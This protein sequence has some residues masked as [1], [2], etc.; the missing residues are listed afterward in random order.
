[1]ISR[2]NRPWVQASWARV[3][4]RRPKRSTSSRDRPRRSAIRSAAR[5]WF[6]MSMSQV[7]GRGVPASIPTLVPSGTRL[8]ASTP[9]AMPALMASAAMRPA[10]R[11]AACC[12]EPH[13]ASRVRQPVWYGRPACSHEVRVML[14]DCSPAWV[15]Q[16][17]ATCSTSAGSMPARSSSAALGAAEDLRG[18]QPCE[19][20]AAFANRCPDSL[21]DHRSAHRS[22]LCARS[23]VPDVAVPD[24][25]V[26]PDWLPHSRTCY[27]I[28]H[29]PLFT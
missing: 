29:D 9:Q 20:P 7:A 27:R 3:C 8:I 1:M 6:G 23:A 12:A 4:E 18:V 17:P 14:L 21:H 28:R 10:T 24:V 5:Y 15:T 22:S 19:Y 26:R 2:S 13:W 16:P 25:L 11:C